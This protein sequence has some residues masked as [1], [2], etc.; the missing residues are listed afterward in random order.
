VRLAALSV[1]PDEALLAFGP[2]LPGA[3]ATFQ[4]SASGDL[5]EA[6]AHLFAGLRALDAEGARRGLA[7]IAAMAV[8]Q[9][10]ADGR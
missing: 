1:G 4:L 10:V 3:G 6:A 5:A 9:P 2:P 8:P 7:R